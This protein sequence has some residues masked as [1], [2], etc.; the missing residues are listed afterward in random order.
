MLSLSA[1][2]GKFVFWIYLIFICCCLT[3]QSCLTLCDPMNS[4]ISCFPVLHYLLE[5]SQAHC[6]FLS[7]KRRGRQ[8][9]RWLDDITNSMDMNLSKLQE[10]VMDRVGLHAAVQG[11]TKSRTP[12]SNWTT[13]KPL[14]SRKSEYNF[15]VG[16]PYLRFLSCGFSHP[17]VMQPCSMYLV[18]KACV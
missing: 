16:P 10:M 9:M 11:V 4:S 18:R 6:P 12:L 15:T 14:C 3:A 5:F 8:R 7:R 17:W 1:L 2:A 13:T